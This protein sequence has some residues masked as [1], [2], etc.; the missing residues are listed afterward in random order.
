MPALGPASHL[1]IYHN[2][3]EGELHIRVDGG[4]AEEAIIGAGRSF[5]CREMTC[6]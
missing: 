1:I 4:D 6:I 3:I 2:V 5:C